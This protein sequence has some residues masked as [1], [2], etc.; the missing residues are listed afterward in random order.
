M[1]DLAISRLPITMACGASAR[2]AIKIGSSG[3]PAKVGNSVHALLHGAVKIYLNQPSEGLHLPPHAVEII[4]EENPGADPKEAFIL[5]SYGLQFL[6]QIIAEGAE[7]IGAEM[8]V[9]WEHGDY[10]VIGHLDLLLK[11]AS[12][13]MAVVDYKTG[14]PEGASDHLDQ[15]RGYLLAVLDEGQGGRAMVVWLKNQSV[16]SVPFSWD[17]LC[18]WEDKLFLQLQR[19]TFCPGDHCF[20]CPVKFSCPAQEQMNRSTASSLLPMAQEEGAQLPSS[21][22]FLASLW[23]RS[24]QVKKALEEYEERVAFSLRDQPE[25]PLPDGRFLRMEHQEWED[26]VFSRNA[27]ETVG[28][29][30]GR[31]IPGLL[32]DLPQ[33]FKISRKIFMDAVAAGAPK[34]RGQAKI[35]IEAAMKILRD[36]GVLET[37]K[38]EFPKAYKTKKESGE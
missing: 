1:I 15:L 3:P 17:A 27:V 22:E 2:E 35:A 29:L 36:A 24:R 19:N 25:I 28:K 4:Q 37:V 32:S 9:S 7:I 31:D 12:G 13:E 33:A 30:M 11:L 20:F 8:E 6:N 5:S 16:D 18:R 26:I 10:R 38:R 21:P 34:G 14:D 23:T